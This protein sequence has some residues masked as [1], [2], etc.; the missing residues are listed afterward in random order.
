MSLAFNLLKGGTTS[1][2][3]KPRGRG[4]HGP[5]TR[6]PRSGAPGLPRPFSFCLLSAPTARI[7]QNPTYPR[8][9]LAQ[10]SPLLDPRLPCPS[11]QLQS[12]SSCLAS[13][14]GT[15]NAVRMDLAFY[16]KP[17]KRRGDAP[18]DP[19]SVISFASAPG[20]SSLNWQA[21]RRAHLTRYIVNSRD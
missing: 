18:L 9:H 5:A 6:L 14:L 8:P 4:A 1:K 16:G 7:Q 17:I 21:I 19:M 15:R 10:D 20:K 12:S 2:S 3:G 13:P 11:L